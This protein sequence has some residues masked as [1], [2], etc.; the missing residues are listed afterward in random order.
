VLAQLLL[1][2]LH[3]AFAVF[4][5]K[6]G[7]IDLTRAGEILESYL[8]NS[9]YAAHVEYVT[10][11]GLYFHEARSFW[12]L[13]RD[14]VTQLFSIFQLGLT[15]LEAMVSVFSIKLSRPHDGIVEMASN[16]LI[17]CVA[18][19]ESEKLN[20]INFPT[21]VTYAHVEPYS[22]RN[23]THVQLHSDRDVLETVAEIILAQPTNPTNSRIE[24]WYA[25]LVQGRNGR[26]I[27]RVLPWSPT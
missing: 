20:S 19:R 14:A 21:T 13:G 24:T 5:R 16:N 6:R 27:T 15:F 10:I 2:S 18:G 9:N 4:P 3:I 12:A 8:D 26:R 11:P 22:S 25:N 23:L 1:G 7:I 17:P